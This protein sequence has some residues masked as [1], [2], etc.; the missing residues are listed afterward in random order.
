MNGGY[1]RIP[2]EI[3]EAL[4]ELTPA[5]VQITMALCRL[6]YGWHRETAEANISELARITGLARLSVRKSFDQV[7]RFFDHDGDTWVVKKLPV[8]GNK[9]TTQVVKKLPPPGKKVTSEVVK[10]LPDLHLPKEKKEKNKE[11]LNGVGELFDIFK[12]ASGHDWPHESTMQYQDYWLKPLESIYNHFG[13]DLAEAERVIREA[14]N[15]Q[16]SGSLGKRYPVNS[17]KSIIKVALDIPPVAASQAEADWQAVR[18]AAA[19]GDA[20]RIP[21]HL[22]PIVRKIGWE[23]LQRMDDYTRPQYQQQFMEARI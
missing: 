2:N 4:P 22:K 18:D 3:I 12:D 16:R 11:R 1:T 7:G 23:K 14:V 13:Q 6:T 5:A 20:A 9:V 15:L 10:K 21:D 19:T 17:P 8:G